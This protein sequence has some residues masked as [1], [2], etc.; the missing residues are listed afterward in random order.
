MKNRPLQ[1]TLKRC[2]A[3]VAISLLAMVASAYAHNN[4]VH[5]A[6][7]AAGEILLN[8]N[9]VITQAKITGVV[10]DEKNLPLPGVSVRIKGTTIGITTDVSGRYS[11]EAGEGAVLVFS[12]IGYTPKEIT[13]GS[14]TE[15][16][17][18][19]LPSSRDL[20]EVVVIGYGTRSQRT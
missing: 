20:T 5:P 15:Y 14:A 4:K 11:I 13:V 10:T 18:Q 3:S 19:I 16:N 17:V 1:K 12:F 6:R 7:P 8:N 2:A 9:A